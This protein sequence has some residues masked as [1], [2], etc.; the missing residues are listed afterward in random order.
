MDLLARGQAS[1][2]LR[3]DIPLR[4]MR[5]VVLGPI[6]HIL[7]E[8]VAQQHPVAAVDIERTA[9]ALTDLLWAAMAA[10]EGEA[11][12]LRQLH[13]D[14]RSALNRADGVG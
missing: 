5:S 4:L 7:W 11:A 10:P 3:A 1:G 2:E 14:L 8:A 6:E 12:R 9:S 13:A